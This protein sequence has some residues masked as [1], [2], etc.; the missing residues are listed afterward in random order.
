MPS[1][2]TLQAARNQ[3]EAEYKF[4]DRF[5]FNK[6]I[7]KT[8][9]ESRCHRKIIKKT[10]KLKPFVMKMGFAYRFDFLF[11]IGCQLFYVA[12]GPFCLLQCELV[13]V[14]HFLRVESL[15]ELF[16]AHQSLLNNDV[17]YRAAGGVGFLSY[18]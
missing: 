2:R 3:N 8:G 7:G 6:G 15:V 9:A 13:G 5:G 16:L 18:L 11:V 10:C 12:D 14:E 4:N 17:I 1:T